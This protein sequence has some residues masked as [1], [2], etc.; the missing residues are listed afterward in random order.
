MVHSKIG[1]I[2]SNS[3]EFRFSEFEILNSN[4]EFEFETEKL[5]IRPNLTELDHQIWEIWIQIFYD[6][7]EDKIIIFGQIM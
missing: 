2:H 1:R 7:N 5:H 6:Q 3:F 4:S